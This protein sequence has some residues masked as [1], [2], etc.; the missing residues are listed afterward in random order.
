[1]KISV[2]IEEG[3]DEEGDLEVERA[4]S[5]SSPSSTVMDVVPKDEGLIVFFLYRFLA[6]TDMVYSSLYGEGMDD[7]IW[8]D[9]ILRDGGRRQTT[10]DLLKVSKTHP[11]FASYIRKLLFT[12]W[13]NPPLSIFETIRTELPGMNANHTS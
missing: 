8:Q 9:V 1:M 4:A 11:L 2:I 7:T 13:T 12:D 5:P 10:K 3:R 6:G